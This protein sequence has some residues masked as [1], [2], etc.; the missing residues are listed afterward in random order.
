LIKSLKNITNKVLS[1]QIFENSTLKIN[2]LL[3][4]ALT[5]FA[6]IAV[7]LNSELAKEKD[8]I[9]FVIESLEDSDIDFHADSGS[10]LNNDL[11]FQELIQHHNL[12]FT[13]QE[14]SSQTKDRSPPELT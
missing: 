8:E 1:S 3:F 13:Q 14:V 6:V 5:L 2:L 7:D 12:S 9:T 4:L 11:P 10:I